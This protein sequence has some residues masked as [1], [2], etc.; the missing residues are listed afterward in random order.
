MDEI[1]LPRRSREGRERKGIPHAIA[2]PSAG[3]ASIATAGQLQRRCC[4]VRQREARLS[5]SRIRRHDRALRHCGYFSTPQV[6]TYT[7]AT[8]YNADA[9]LRLLDSYS[10]YRVLEPDLHERLFNAVRDLIATRFGGQVTRQ[11][12]A[13]LFVAR[14]R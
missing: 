6:R 11:W 3:R 4:P 2:P 13:E 5:R 1:T 9:Y 12:R 8:T 14:R 10:S 7:W